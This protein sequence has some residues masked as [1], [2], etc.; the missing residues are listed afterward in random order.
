VEQV[1]GAESLALVLR[2]LDDAFAGTEQVR[3]SAKSPS[4]SAKSG[5][6]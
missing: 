1:C 3:N 5:K 2:E 4:L 6:R